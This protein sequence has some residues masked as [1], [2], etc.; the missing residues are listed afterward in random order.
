MS[1]RNEKIEEDALSIVESLLS[2]KKI[3]AKEAAILIK[4][5]CDKGGGAPYVIPA[6]QNAVQQPIP[7]N[8]PS[9]DPPE[10]FPWKP[11]IIYAS[12]TGNG[13]DGVSST[14]NIV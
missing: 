14:L 12:D 11:G 2:D 10:P 8:V 3:T 5:I 9:V 13:F 6:Q 4:A 7:Q 1:K